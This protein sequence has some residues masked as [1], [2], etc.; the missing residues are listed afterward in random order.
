[1]WEVP[2]I[3]PHVTEHQCPTVC[4]PH[5]QTPVRAPRPPDVPPGAF[6]PRVAALVSLLHGRYRLSDRETVALLT[7]LCGLP[8][9]LGSVPALCQT[10]GAALAPVYETVQTTV[11]TQSI[12]NVDETSWKE[13]GARRWLWVAVTAVCTLFRVAHHRSAAALQALLG[14]A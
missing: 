7:D 10:V 1:M 9:R 8:E 5:C 14:D 3:Q 11:E 13:A 2:S 4:C 6:G 12:A